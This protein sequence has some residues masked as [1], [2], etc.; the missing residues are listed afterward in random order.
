MVFVANLVFR[1]SELVCEVFFGVTEELDCLP[2]AEPAVLLEWSFALFDTDAFEADAFEAD[3]FEADAFEADAFEADAFEA[4][5]FDADNDF[6]LCFLDLDADECF[7]ICLALFAAASDVGECEEIDE[8]VVLLDERELWLWE[9]DFGCVDVLE[10]VALEY[11]E[12][13]GDSEFV[14]GLDDVLGLVD[15]LLGV[16]DCGAVELDS[17]PVDVGD[18]LCRVVGRVECDEREEALDDVGVEDAG[19]LS[20]GWLDDEEIVLCSPD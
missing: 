18:E 2:V 12:E 19:R 3:A 11:W 17:C 16:D 15:T 7:D 13:R 6:S 8:L 14:L 1:W 20:V 10:F 4:D 9:S 5:A